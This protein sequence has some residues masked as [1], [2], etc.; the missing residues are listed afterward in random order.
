MRVLLALLGMAPL[1]GAD[2][3]RVDVIDNEVWI[4]HNPE[5]DA[6]LY[7]GSGGA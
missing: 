6:G 5:S 4:A 7:P 3:V 1:F 2:I